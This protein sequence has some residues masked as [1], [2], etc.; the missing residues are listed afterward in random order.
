MK[1]LIILCVILMVASMVPMAAAI[2]VDGDKDPG[3]WSD[4]WAYNQSQGTGYAIHGPFGD[5]LVMMQGGIDIPY[6]PT[7]VADEDPQDDGGPAPFDDEIGD[8]NASGFD[9]RSISVHY[10]ATTHILY[11]LCE[12]YGMPGDLDG[13]GTTSTPDSTI[14]G[15]EV[16][17]TGP[18]GEGIGPEESWEIKATQGTDIVLIIVTNNNWTVSGSTSLSYDQVTAKFSDST[19]GVYEILIED[20]NTY[21]DV[22]FGADPVM[23][24]V[25]AGGSRHSPGED[26][27]TAFVYFPDPSIMIEKSTNGVDA[28]TPTGPTLGM[29]DSVTWEYVVTNNGSDPLRNIVVDDDII[30]PI[31]LPTNT[32][33]VGQSTNATVVGTVNAHGQ[34]ANLATVYGDF[35][36]IPVKDDDPSHYIVP[37][38][39][40]DIQIVKTT[41]D[42]LGGWMD[43]PLLNTNV[44][45]TWRYVV[46][47]IGDVPLTGI[48]VSD[49][50]EGDISSGHSLGISG[51]FT[52]TK[53][54]TTVPSGSYTNLATVV[55]YYENTQVD[56]TDPS[57]YR[58]RPP[59]DVPALT[60]T[61][62]LGLIGVLGMIGIVGVKRRD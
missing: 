35:A 62:L 59:V 50:K 42:G 38:P 1:K 28:D 57:N 61:G 33:A 40:P 52:V 32:L 56:D 4:N 6:D 18:A 43:G 45:V 12:V 51:S 29:G 20:M 27:A 21:F 30:G 13:D 48:N 7:T 54:G 34:Y 5:R 9:I 11:G 16:G 31:G 47:N 39:R 26:T 25:R 44:S 36:G 41:S 60:P 8:P 24:E 15:D 2:N 58:T 17:D 46:T 22:N 10:N 3:E 55:G 23:I 14:I 37:Q 49:N 19:D 53:D